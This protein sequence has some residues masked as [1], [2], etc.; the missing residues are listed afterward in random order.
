MYMRHPLIAEVQS[1]K[2]KEIQRWLHIVLLLS[3]MVV[4]L[5]ILYQY[6]EEAVTEEIE[7]C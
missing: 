2:L 3:W 1:H 5:C 7:K 6:S 4:N